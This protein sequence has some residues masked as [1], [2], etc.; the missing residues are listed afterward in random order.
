MNNNVISGLANPTERNDVVH[1]HYAKTSINTID[2]QIEYLQGLVTNRTHQ[3][4]GLQPRGGD[5]KN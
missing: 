4:G 5:L 1:K 3:L 2:S